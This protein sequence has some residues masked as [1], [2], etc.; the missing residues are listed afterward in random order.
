MMRNTGR[1]SHAVRNL[2]YLER[3]PVIVRTYAED[4]SA[5]GL[6]NPMSMVHQSVDEL[7]AATATT[8]R[9]METIGVC[10]CVCVCV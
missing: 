5:G 8:Q 7:V 2:E 9:A 6:L 4:V 3:N 1:P 10:V